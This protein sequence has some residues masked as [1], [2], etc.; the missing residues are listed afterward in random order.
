MPQPRGRVVLPGG[1]PPRGPDR[2]V[3]RGRHGQPRQHI[4]SIQRARILDAFV[5]VVGRQGFAKSRITEVCAAAGV[6]TREFYALFDSKH[7]CFLAALDE[8]SEVLVSQAITAYRSATGRWEQ[9]VCVALTA[10][11]SLLAANPAFARLCLLEVFRVGPPANERINSAI[12]TCAR[13]LGGVTAP[14]PPPHVPADAYLAALAGAMLRPLI[15]YVRDEKTAE[16]PGLAPFLT[17]CLALPL[18]GEERALCV[19]QPGSCE[20]SVTETTGR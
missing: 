3:P 9:R 13:E 8:G 11:L 1:R 12:R 5:E 18:V 2:V 19:L 20:S 16:L 17:Y 14:T 6:S 10:I 15:Q 7:D 4:R